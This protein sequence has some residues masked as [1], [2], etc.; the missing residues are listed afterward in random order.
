MVL[1]DIDDNSRTGTI[2]LRPNSSWSWRANVIF[3]SFFMGVSLTIAV[4]FMIAGAWVIMPYSILEVTVVGLCIHYC[5]RQ[6]SRQEVITISDF[7]VKI[8]SGI[9]EPSKAQ[10]FQRM[11][12]KFFVTRPRRPWES[13]TL[14][15]RSHGH[16]T[17]IGSFLSSTD[18]DDLVSQLKRVVPN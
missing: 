5:V 11:W 13:A 4:G 2:I 15:I 1:T 9:R 17:E 10:T 6:C 18:K 16:E 3:L 12:A 14:S 7:E 8:E